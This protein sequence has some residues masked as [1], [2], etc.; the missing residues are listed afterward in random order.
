VTTEYLSNE[1]FSSI[2]LDRSTQPLRGGDSQPAEAAPVGE[3]EQRRQSAAGT[4]S[5]LIGLLE[6][7][8]APDAFVRPQACHNGPL[9]VL[10][11]W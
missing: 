5:M 4:H 9:P 8:T 7:G 1:S 10:I 2:P 3:N 6:V 11:R